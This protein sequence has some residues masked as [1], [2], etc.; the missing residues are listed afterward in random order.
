M[1]LYIISSYCFRYAVTHLMYKMKG[2]YENYVLLFAETIVMVAFCY[3]IHKVMS[4]NVLCR[5]LLFGRWK[6]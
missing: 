3:L 5:R 6:K 4:R 2:T 1:E